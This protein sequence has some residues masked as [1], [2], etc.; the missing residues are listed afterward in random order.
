MARNV[1]STIEGISLSVRPL[2]PSFE[3]MF[4]LQREKALN[5]RARLNVIIPRLDELI[6]EVDRELRK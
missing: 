3:I 5:Q 2:H 1:A 6:T 4:A